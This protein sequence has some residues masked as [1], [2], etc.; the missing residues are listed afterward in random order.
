M[1]VL[2]PEGQMRK[3]QHKSGVIMTNY[4]QHLPLSKGKVC[5][6]I[7]LV[8]GKLEQL[9]RPVVTESFP[10]VTPVVRLHH[11]PVRAALSQA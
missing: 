10:S 5:Y 3:Q 9:N 2:L 1:Q 7:T 4:V 11:V 8:D 6:L